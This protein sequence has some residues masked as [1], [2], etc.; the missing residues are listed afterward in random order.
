MITTH[1]SFRILSSI[2][3]SELFSQSTGKQCMKLETSFA[4]F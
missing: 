2:L 3:V 4:G 1:L